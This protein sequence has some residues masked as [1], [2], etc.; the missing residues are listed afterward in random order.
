MYHF[1]FFLKIKHN[2]VIFNRSDHILNYQ[3]CNYKMEQKQRNLECKV[4]FFAAIFKML[5]KK[6]K[7]R[8]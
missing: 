6:F 7:I 2:I 8:L 5:K 3:N 1:N 4:F